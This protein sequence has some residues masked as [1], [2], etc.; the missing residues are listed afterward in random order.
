M[1]VRISK[2]NKCCQS[3]ETRQGLD[4]QVI[5]LFLGFGKKVVNLKKAVLKDML[6][7]LAKCGKG[8]ML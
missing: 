6:I 7:N 4:V 2:A 1:E 3:A 5:V 8:E